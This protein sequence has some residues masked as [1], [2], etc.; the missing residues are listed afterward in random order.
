[1]FTHYTICDLRVNC[2]GFRKTAFRQ[3]VQPH[4]FLP[5]RVVTIS[6]ELGMRKMRFF[7]GS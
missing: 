2:E 5:C 7:A 3:D 4:R 6:I 1:M